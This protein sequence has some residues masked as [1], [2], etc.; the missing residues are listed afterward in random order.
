M[1]DYY[2]NNDCYNNMHGGDDDTCLP[3]IHRP[4]IDSHI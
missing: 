4:V 3:F 2:N 1:I